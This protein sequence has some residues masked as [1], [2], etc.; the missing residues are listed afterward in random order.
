LLAG[1]LPFFFVALPLPALGV[2]PGNKPPM[3]LPPGDGTVPGAVPVPP[4]LPGAGD[5]G[6]AGAEGDGLCEGE[7]KMS[8]MQPWPC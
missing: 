5:D 1:F 4:L 3:M 2:A 7:Q 6:A 8:R